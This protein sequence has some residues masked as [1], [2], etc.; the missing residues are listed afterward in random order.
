MSVAQARN[1]PGDIDQTS[2]GPPGKRPTN[3][4]TWLTATGGALVLSVVFVWP[5][6]QVSGQG[7]T[8]PTASP[9]ATI[10]IPETTEP[11]V[12]PLTAQTITATKIQA[13][14]ALAATTLDT[15]TTTHFIESH[16]SDGSG[17]NTECSENH[18][19]D[20][21]AHAADCANN[22]STEGSGHDSDCSGHEAHGSDHHAHGSDH[23]DS[24]AH[25]ADC[26]NN[27]STDGSGHHSD[28]TTS[29]TSDGS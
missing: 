6:A 26:A 8:P 21:A 17:H 18:D 23:A 12:A 13:A 7:V 15:Q 27:H 5:A 22:H 25:A 4:K 1:N 29:D 10:Q 19:A 2:T 14:T 28:C 24:A 11:D 16:S 9:D 3:P 20:P